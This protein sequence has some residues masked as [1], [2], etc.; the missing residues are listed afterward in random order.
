MGG[1]FGSTTACTTVGP[2]WLQRLAENALRILG[3]LDGEAARAAGLRH[4]G[5]VDGLKL[6]AELRIAFEDHLLPLDLAENV[7]LDDDDGDAQLVFDQRRDLAHQHGEAAIADDADDLASG[8][9]DGCANAVGQSVG[10]GGQRAGERELHGA[11][12]LDVA[13]CPGRDGAAVGGD[14]GVVIEQPVERVG[15]DLR[16]HRHVLCACRALPS[17]HSRSSSAP[18]L[19]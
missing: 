18:G 1:S 7:V 15:D 3:T 19:S 10:H 13:R 6:D 16:L 9:G 11:A 8:I 17:A 12:H 14:D 4:H 2:S 5:E